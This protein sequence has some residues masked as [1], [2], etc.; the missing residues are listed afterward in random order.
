MVRR[1]DE[2]PD[3]VPFA[4]RKNFPCRRGRAYD[5]LFTFDTATV[6]IFSEHTER[7]RMGADQQI[8]GMADNEMAGRWR[9]ALFQHFNFHNRADFDGREAGE[10][11]PT[12]C[13][14][15]KTRNV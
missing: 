11:N 5:Q 13:H 6:K 15:V 10:I 7:W 2:S 1:G 4:K 9:I 12:Y 8:V 14:A 3:V